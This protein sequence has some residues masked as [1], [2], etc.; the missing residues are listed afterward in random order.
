MARMFTWP[1]ADSLGEF[2]SLCNSEPQAR[3]NIST[4]EF[5]QTFLSVCI[6]LYKQEAAVF[7]KQSQQNAFCTTCFYDWQGH[8]GAYTAETQLNIKKTQPR[9][10]TSHQENG[11]AKEGGKAKKTLVS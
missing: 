2:K 1:D 4:F 10:Q 6:R 11:R 8:V 3:V 7:L 5:S 9:T